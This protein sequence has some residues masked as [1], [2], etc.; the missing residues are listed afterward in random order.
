MKAT[1]SPPTH[2]CQVGDT[3]VFLDLTGDRYFALEPSA[4]ER[5]SR[6]VHGEPGEGD[7][8]WLA[9]RCLHNLAAPIEQSCQR[10]ISPT[11]SL[12]EDPDLGKASVE[13]TARAILS[14]AIARRSVRRTALAKI[15]SHFPRCKPQPLIIQKAQAREVATAFQRARHYISGLDECLG[16]GIAMRR[17]LAGKGCEAR[18]IIGV[19][20]PFAAHCWVQLG[21][22]VLTDP[23]D[24]VAPYK[25]I[26]IV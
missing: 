24:L 26:L 7:R 6:I 14:L 3:F 15:L 4:G 13:Q 8:E 9:A 22:T 17:V 19:T 21:E 2:W 18:L 1:V 23:L 5:F 20:L 10:F 11:R 16:R 12:L 25:P